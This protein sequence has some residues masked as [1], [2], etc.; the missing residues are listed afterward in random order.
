MMCPGGNWG[1]T[2]SL[3]A[4]SLAAPFAVRCADAALHPLQLRRRAKWY[5]RT[6]RNK[7]AGRDPKEVRRKREVYQV[8]LKGSK[9]SK[10]IVS[11]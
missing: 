9:A 3:N 11:L 6:G 2:S 1:V 8:A 7:E 10:A 4:S 5:V